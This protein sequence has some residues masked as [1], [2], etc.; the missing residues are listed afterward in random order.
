MGTRYG[1][2]TKDDDAQKWVTSTIW[3]DNPH[4]IVLHVALYLQHTIVN[5]KKPIVRICSHDET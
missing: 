4:E 5:G 2:Q 1:F 3:S